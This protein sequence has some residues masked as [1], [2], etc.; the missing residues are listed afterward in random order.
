MK[1]RQYIKTIIS[2]LIILFV[3]PSRL[4][5]STNSV[6]IGK[7][8]P[9]FLLYGFNKRNHIKKKWSLDDFSGNWLILY[10]YPKDFSSGCTLQ[11]KAFQDNLSK[12]QKCPE[13]ANLQAQE[14]TTE[15]QSAIPILEPKNYSKQICNNVDYG[16]KKKTNGSI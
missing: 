2:F 6:K 12:F 13:F 15:C 11:A 9:D 4:F 10:F 14:L 1:R 5:A 16:G 7:K 3:K 8:A